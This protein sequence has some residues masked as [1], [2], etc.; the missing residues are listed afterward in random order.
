V[1]EALEQHSLPMTRHFEVLTSALNKNKLDLLNLNHIKACLQT[2]MY[3]GIFQVKRRPFT[4]LLSI[5]AFIRRGNF[6][7]QVH[8]LFATMKGRKAAGGP[9]KNAISYKKS[10]STM[11]WPCE[12]AVRHVFP[13]TQIKGCSFYWGLAVRQKIQ[14]GVF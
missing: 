4:M 2:S 14:V 7:K 12:K 11:R 10:S 8:L 6:E 13:E 5:H 9:C 1:D 3:V